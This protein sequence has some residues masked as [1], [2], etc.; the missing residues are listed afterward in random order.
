MKR[1]LLFVGKVYYPNEGM[2]DLISDFDEL[3]NA[4]IAVIEV[5]KKE[6]CFVDYEAYKVYDEMM[7]FQIYDT[8][9]RI[10][11]RNDFCR[12]FKRLNLNIKIEA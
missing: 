7:Y 10:A 9:K 3:K 12:L 6:D 11:V 8:Q 1:Y 4:E 2:E 5:L